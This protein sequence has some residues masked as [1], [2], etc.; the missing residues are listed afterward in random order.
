MRGMDEQKNSGLRLSLLI[1]SAIALLYAIY[2][3]ESSY[4]RFNGDPADRP[5]AYAIAVIVCVGWTGYL[6]YRSIKSSRRP[7]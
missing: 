5:R 3:K 6:L 4:F 7:K 1:L 2:L